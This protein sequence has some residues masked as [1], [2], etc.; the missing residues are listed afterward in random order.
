[1]M[2]IIVLKLNVVEELNNKFIVQRYEVRINKCNFLRFVIK[3]LK[4]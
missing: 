4:F 2:Q 1:M 3:C